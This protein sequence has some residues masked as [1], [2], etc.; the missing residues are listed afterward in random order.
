MPNQR[1]YSQTPW[2][3]RVG[4]CRAI[5]AGAW[6]HVSG[7]TAVDEAGRPVSVGDIYGQT[8][9]ILEKIE[10]ALAGL[11]AGPEHVVRTRMYVTDIRQWEAVGRAHG[12]H[13]REIKPAT[14]LVE[15]SALIDPQ[16][17]VEIEAVA[18]LPAG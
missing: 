18:M 13:F 3:D 16:L 17:L 15:V 12:E 1:V 8:R 10:K 4:Y 14:T 7:T 9:F 2:E 5:K 11:S 6:I